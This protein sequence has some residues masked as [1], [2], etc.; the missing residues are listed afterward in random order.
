MEHNQEGETQRHR[1]VKHKMLIKIVNGRAVLGKQQFKMNAA[2]A[3]SEATHKLHKARRLRH[4]RKE[5]TYREQRV[6]SY[7]IDK[8]VPIPPKSSAGKPIK[9]HVEVVRRMEVGDSFY[10]PET[11]Y[12]TQH[13]RMKYWQKA[14]GF[15]LTARPWDNGVRIWRVE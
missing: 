3:V 12:Y 7:V 6:A 9:Y 2:G 13:G 11:S 8:D 15:K 4:K 14:T 5:P 1:P 10:I